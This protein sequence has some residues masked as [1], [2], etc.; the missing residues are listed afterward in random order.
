MPNQS[1]EIHAFV[2]NF[3]GLF[4]TQQN[5]TTMPEQIRETRKNGRA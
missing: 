5:P 1:A 3:L 4:K 2:M